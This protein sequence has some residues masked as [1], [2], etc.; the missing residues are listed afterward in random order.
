MIDRRF[1]S[2]R[3]VF[4]RESF[5]GKRAPPV[6]RHHRGRSGTVACIVCTS[7]GSTMACSRRRRIAS[8]KRCATQPHPTH[9]EVLGGGGKVAYAE[10]HRAPMRD[11]DQS[12]AG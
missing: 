7:N 9:N 4:L 10:L 11:I 2:G 1:H 12:L 8:P 5:G 3:G 6:I